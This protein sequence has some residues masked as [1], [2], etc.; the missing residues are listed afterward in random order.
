MAL[1]IANTPNTGTILLLSTHI[2]FWSHVKTCRFG[3]QHCAPV[4][5][6]QDPFFEYGPK[7]R[8]AA[9][10]QKPQDP[11]FMSDSTKKK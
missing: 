6:P 5:K 7:A 3:P 8:N 1:I 11:F 10:V 9:P 4:Q 2:F